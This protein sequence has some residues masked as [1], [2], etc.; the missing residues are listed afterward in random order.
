MP[1]ASIEHIFLKHKIPTSI[2]FYSVWMLNIKHKRS[3]GDVIKFKTCFCV[4]GRSQEL[5]VNY[6]ETYTPDVKQNTIRTC[7]TM[8]IAHSWQTRAIEFDQA[9]NQEDFDSDAHL[10][11]PEGF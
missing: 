10:C 8:T 11:L 3:S 5:G 1:I 4:D 7:L 2:I 6:H 9:C